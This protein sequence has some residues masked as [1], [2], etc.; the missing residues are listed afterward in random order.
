[1]RRTGAREKPPASDGLA[2]DRREADA[3]SRERILEAAAVLFAEHGYSGTSV[4]AV[5]REVG[6]TK[7]AIYWHF[8]SK[9]GL[10]AEVL[11][12]SSERLIERVQ[13]ITSGLAGPERLNALT[14]GWRQIVRED[15]HLLRLPGVAAGE[16][17]GRSEPIREALV[18]VWQR[19]EE[20]ICRGFEETL[21]S[22][23]PDADLIA[24][25][26]IVLLQGALLR[27]SVD[28]DPVQLDRNLEELR[29][30]VALQVLARQ[31]RETPPPRPAPS[32][33]ETLTSPARGVPISR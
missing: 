18:K 26:V 30:I 28:R 5:C 7:P 20:A 23:L 32:P 22:A 15:A 25:T 17:A 9:E 21:G 24:H 12:T 31:S 16:L 6:L 13:R 19:A 14:E 29:H 27:H 2:P 4:A 1:M 10:L 3:G 33:Y 8:G 11:E